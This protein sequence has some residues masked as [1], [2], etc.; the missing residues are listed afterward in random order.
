MHTTAMCEVNFCLVCRNYIVCKCNVVNSNYPNSGIRA[1]KVLMPVSE[2]EAIIADPI[3]GDEL[4]R[5][6][7]KAREHEVL[8]ASRFAKAE[9]VKA[10]MDTK[11]FW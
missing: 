1:V 9:V 4:T 3:A 10:T 11:S 2:L 5:V 7:N 6:V 8:V